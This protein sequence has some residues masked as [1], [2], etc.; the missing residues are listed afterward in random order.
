MPGETIRGEK[1]SV[2]GYL[3]TLFSLQGEMVSRKSSER[4][5]SDGKKKIRPFN[6]DDSG[7]F[8]KL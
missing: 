2:R 5:V 6:L 3:A 4:K 7:G 1:R 8:T